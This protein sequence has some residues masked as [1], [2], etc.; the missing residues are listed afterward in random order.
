MDKLLFVHI[1]IKHILEI[2]NFISDEERI[3]LL[4]AIDNLPF[5]SL[6]KILKILYKVEQEYFQFLHKDTLQL[7]S[8]V[9]S[10]KSAYDK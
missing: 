2:L 10:L 7:N 3:K 4:A 8:F 5:N 9:K 1:E 6:V